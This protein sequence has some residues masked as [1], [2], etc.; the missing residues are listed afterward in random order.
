MQDESKW[1]AGWIALK[2]K[3]K[4]AQNQ[5]DNNDLMHK[6]LEADQAV[7]DYELRIKKEVGIEAEVYW[8]EVWVELSRK[9]EEAAK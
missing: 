2:I 7:I 6:S 8:R 1:L 3:Q 9:E 4:I 5:Y